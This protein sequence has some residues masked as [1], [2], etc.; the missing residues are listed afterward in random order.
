[1]AEFVGAEIE[2]RL[3]LYQAFLK[4]YEHKRSV[5]DEI[6]ESE[7]L[8]QPSRTKA[9]SFY[10]QGVI[11]G[12]EV[13][14]ITNLCEGTTQQLRQP[15]KIWTVGRECDSGIH[16]LDSRV[17]R[18][19]GAI[20]YIDEKG[21]FYLLDFSSTNGSFVNGEPV[22]EPVKLNDGDSIR[23]GNTTFEFFLNSVTRTL[24]TVATELLTQLVCERT[25]EV[26]LVTYQSTKTQV[27][28]Q[29]P[30][31]TIEILKSMGY[32]DRDDADVKQPFL[33]GLEQSPE[34]MDYFLGKKVEIEA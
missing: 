5:L 26:K 11:D 12:S 7:D 33:L 23:L 16:L 3:S 15:Q 4:L 10:F 19:H 31:P 20:Q 22:F 18:R 29:H 6:L 25:K 27:I 13:Y 24:P 17:S 32:I 8:R 2:R 28:A 9:K 21:S 30:D 1:M 14:A 34:I